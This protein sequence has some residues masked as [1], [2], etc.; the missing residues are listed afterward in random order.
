MWITSSRIYSNSDVQSKLTENERKPKYVMANKC[1]NVNTVHRLKL[2]CD[3]KDL[4]GGLRSRSICRSFSSIICEKREWNMVQHSSGW[5][6]AC[7]INK[8]YLK[9]YRS[10]NNNPRLLTINPTAKELFDIYPDV[11]NIVLDIVV[12][13][14]TS[15]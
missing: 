10:Q 3:T 8:I 6:L 11:K 4:L 7:F 9:I 13:W 2:K 14:K 5:F 15:I 1:T 12:N